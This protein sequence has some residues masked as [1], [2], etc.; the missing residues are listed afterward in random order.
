MISNLISQYR[1][2]DTALQSAVRQDSSAQVKELDEQ[3]AD[4]WE[5]ILH[6]VPEND[7]QAETLINFLFSEVFAIDGKDGKFGQ[8]R[9]KI[10]DIVRHSPP[11]EQP[12]LSTYADRIFQIFGVHRHLASKASQ[13]RQTNS[14]QFRS[15]ISREGEVIYNSSRAE[16]W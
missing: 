16:R 9:R 3:V 10:V 7:Q 6:Y 15:P 11:A 5:Q 4:I 14:E 12:H 1:T 13:R 2:L 8:V